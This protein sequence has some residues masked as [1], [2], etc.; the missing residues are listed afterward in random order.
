MLAHP[1]SH[2]WPRMYTSPGQPS[3]S[4]CLSL[5]CPHAGTSH[6]SSQNLP[7]SHPDPNSG[8]RATPWMITEGVQLSPA[9]VAPSVPCT[10][11]CGPHCMLPTA[12]LGM[13]SNTCA[14]T[15]GQDQMLPGSCPP[16]RHLLMCIPP[17]QASA[18][19][20][21]SARCAS[22]CPGGKPRSLKHWA[23]CACPQSHLAAAAP[24]P[25]S[26]MQAQSRRWPDV[27]PL[28]APLQ[29]G[30]HHCPCEG[31]RLP[32]SRSYPSLC[33]VVPSQLFQIRLSKDSGLCASQGSPL[34]GRP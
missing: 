4:L 34:L 5:S 18:A 1:N 8:H 14:G 33:P 19:A 10:S 7:P 11:S 12:T 24:V 6:P 27:C 32:S 29:P 3:D 2:P 15:G 25:P 17:C 16:G 9:P 23:P 26:T 28:G 31:P 22:S 30:T 21:P 13:K 20:A